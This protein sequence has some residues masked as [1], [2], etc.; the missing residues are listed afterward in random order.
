MGQCD[1]VLRVRRYHTGKRP[2]VVVLIERVRAGQDL[3]R[4][5]LS[6]YRSGHTDALLD[7][8]SLLHPV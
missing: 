2:V 5:I 6:V 4:E 8:V 7:A 1:G 3:V